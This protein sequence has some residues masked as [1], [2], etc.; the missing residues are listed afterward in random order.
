MLLLLLITGPHCYCVAAAVGVGNVS[1]AVGTRNIAIRA[2][3]NRLVVVSKVIVVVTA[4]ADGGC[5]SGCHSVTSLVLLLQKRYERK[6]NS[7]NIRNYQHLRCWQQQYGDNNSK[8]QHQQRQVKSENR[9]S[10]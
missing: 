5:Y 7:R 10:N 9:Q 2:A 6:H 3:L 4:C 8:Q 1:L